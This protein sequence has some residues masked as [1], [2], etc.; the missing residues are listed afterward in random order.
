[1]TFYHVYTSQITP[2]YAL[3][4]DDL[5]SDPYVTDQGGMHFKCNAYISMNS[6]VCFLACAKVLGNTLNF[7][8][9]VTV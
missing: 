5:C 4:K 8:P 2:A 6:A 1:M 3:L 7:F 9:E